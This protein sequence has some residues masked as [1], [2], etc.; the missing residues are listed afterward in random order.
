MRL[1]RNFPSTGVTEMESHTINARGFAAANLVRKLG[2]VEY[3]WS[4]VTKQPSG[5]WEWDKPDN[6]GY[7]R[8]YIKDGRRLAHRYSY[9]LANGPIPS[10]MCVCHRCDNRRCVNP[11]HLFLG[12]YLDNARDKA[13]KGRCRN[14]TGEQH[15]NAKLTSAHV[16]LI[17]ARAGTDAELARRFGVAP[18]TV[19]K[20]RIGE[21]WR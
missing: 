11:A 3:F 5:C 14:V 8:I 16:A 10:G 19:R 15:P 13:V 2:R 9:E 12:T 17:K 20:V 1:A 7:G 4:R 21:S 18:P 6:H